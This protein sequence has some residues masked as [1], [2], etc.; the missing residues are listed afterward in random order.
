MR[1]ITVTIHGSDRPLLSDREPALP[2]AASGEG[3]D[4]G[5]AVTITTRRDCLCPY[6]DALKWAYA[7]AAPLAES[8]VGVKERVRRL[9]RFRDHIDAVLYPKEVGTNG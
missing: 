7:N 2:G 3:N 4:P 9:N 6:R 1:H 8:R 5:R